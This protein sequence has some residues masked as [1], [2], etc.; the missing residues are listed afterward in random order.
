MK[1]F[2]N[3]FK[4]FIMRGNVLDLAVGVIIGAAFQAI[5][6]SLTNDIISPILGIFGGMNFDNLSI[7]INGATLAY[8]KFITAVINFLIMAFIIFLI[9]KLVNKVMSFGK[10]KKTEEAPTTKTCPFCMSEID[11]KATRCPHC[12]SELPT[13]ASDNK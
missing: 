11:I 6:T 4:T 2:F 13:D 1:K 10:K 8:G 5:V 9:V 3:E 12:T 7:D